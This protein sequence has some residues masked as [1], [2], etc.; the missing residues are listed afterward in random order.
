MTMCQ[1]CARRDP[2]TQ[3][4]SKD[5]GHNLCLLCEDRHTAEE[6]TREADKRVT[7]VPY[8]D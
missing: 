3:V 4:W 2:S 5:C 6:C 7:E 1:R 8:G